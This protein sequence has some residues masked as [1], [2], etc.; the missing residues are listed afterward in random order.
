MIF[1]EHLDYDG[2]YELDQQ[3]EE[4][5]ATTLRWWQMYVYS[6][7]NFTTNVL[8]GMF[9]DYRKVLAPTSMVKT[10]KMKRAT[11]PNSRHPGR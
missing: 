6:I 8:P 11:C 3:T 4:W 1:N 2:D 7:H 5:I 9:L 10:V